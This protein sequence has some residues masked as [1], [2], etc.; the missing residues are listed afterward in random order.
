MPVPVG[1]EAKGVDGVSVPARAEAVWRDRTP[2]ASSPGAPQDRGI[3]FDLGRG[4]VVHFATLQNVWEW[5]G[6]NWTERKLLG[7]TPTARGGYAVAYDASRGRVV[8]F[9]GDAPS[10]GFRSDTWEWDGTTWEDKTPLSASPPA[11]R[12]HAM[13]YDSARGRVMMFGG[14][15]GSS[16]LLQD[17]WEWNGKTWANLTPSAS[18]PI[19][20]SMHGL[21]FDGSRNRLVMFGGDAGAT[22]P[23]LPRQD[24]W[25]W[26]GTAWV[27]RTPAAPLPATRMGHGMVFDGGRGRVVV[28]GGLSNQPGGGNSVLFSDTWEWDGTSWLERAPLSTKPT[29]HTNVLMVF[30]SSRKR[31]VVFGGLGG[32]SDTWE[33]DGNAWSNRTPQPS[34]PPPA[35]F[36]STA[37]DPVRGRAVLMGLE[38]VWEWDGVRWLA[39]SP[40]G[41]APSLRERAAAVFDPA[42]KRI[43]Y[44]GG[45]IGYASFKQDTW[46]WDGTTWSERTPAG[47]PPQARASHAMAFDSRR[48]RVVLFGGGT[49]VGLIAIEGGGTLHLHGLRQDTWEWDGSSWSDRTPSQ[50][51]SPRAGH[52]MAFD[53]ERGR[54][55]MAGGYK[56]VGDYGSVALQDVWEWDGAAWTERTPPGPKPTARSGHA[57][58]FDASQKQTLLF[59]GFDGA[60]KQ[61]LWRWEGASWTEK[62]LAGPGPFKRTGHLMAFDSLRS[63]SVIFGGMYTTPIAGPF[64]RGGLT[65]QLADTWELSAD[66]SRQAAVQ[67]S[68]SAKATGILAPS[69]TGLRVRAHCGGVFFPYSATSIGSTLLGFDPTAS[70]TGA[71][72]PLGT[73]NVGINASQPF[74]PAPN[75]ARMDWSVAAPDARRYFDAS[76]QSLSFQCRPSGS[77][78]VS[79]KESAVALDYIEVR[80]KYTAP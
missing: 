33:W 41:P 17:L 35:A 67:F 60:E 32:A 9:G 39:I 78:G 8:L 15:S 1:T 53:S 55:V 65:Q 51:P 57:M 61:D 7:R 49:Q 20:R 72:V 43:V 54:V 21:V 59:G 62:T 18:K 38:K 75:T 10:G 40:P 37:F 42:R 13:T 12:D 29:Q 30:D 46:E 28:F 26:D 48:N 4:R 66:P 68:A 69:I 34:S 71:W 36:Q 5:D 79:D 73:N 19:A 56:Q 80:V 3:V 45:L 76:D 44:F 77:S 24:L 23:P 16:G 2:A 63:K 74:L 27:D 70:G 22:W 58:A 31:S 52:A 6:V 47:P 64:G 14:K 25:E 50:N 11:R